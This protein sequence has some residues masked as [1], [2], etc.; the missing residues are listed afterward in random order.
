MN[1]HIF[2]ML[3]GVLVL[4]LLASGAVG[5]DGWWNTSLIKN[6]S[7]SNVSSSSKIIYVPDDYAKIQWAVDNASAGDTIIVRDGIYYENVNVN[8]RLTIRS[9]NGSANCIVDAR[10]SGDVIE[11]S[12][13]GITIE[14]FTVRNSGWGYRGIRVTSSNNNII[15]NN[16][17][18]NNWDG[19]FLVYSS[20]NTITNNCI[21]NNWDGIS[22]DD[23][24]NNNITNNCISNN[25]YYGIL[26]YY[27]SNNNIITNNCISNNSVGISLDYWSNNNIITNNCISSNNE[28]GIHLVHS[29][30]NTITGNTMINDGILIEGY[31][32]QHWNTHT[33]EDNTVNGKPLYYFK[34][35]VGGKVPED[36]GQVI[37]ANCTGMKIENLNVSNT[38]GGIV[39]GFSSQNT[40]KDNNI[41][42]N[43]DG[44][45]L[46]HS[47]N[48]TITNNCISSNNWSGIYLDCSSNN[49]IT[50]N[51][52]SNNDEGISL[53]YWS[54]NNTITNNCIS[55]NNWDGILLHDASN[56]IITNNCIS[57]NDDGIYLS[58]SGNNNITNNCISNNSVGI[59]LWSSKNNNITNNCISNNSLGIHLYDSSN[60]NITNNCISSNNDEGILLADSCCNIITNNC[61]SNNYWGIRLGG[62][63]N[64]IT[65]NCISNNTY[66][67]YLGYSSNNVIYLNNFINNTDQVY[68][69]KTNIWN[70]TSKI[71]Y[72]YK[73][74][75]Y[76]NYMGNYW[77]DYKG[78]DTDKD[79]IGDTPYS[80]DGD[81]DN[82]PL[83][84]RFENYT[85]E[86]SV[87]SPE[88]FISTDKYEYT[89]G[90]TMLINIS[91][92]NPTE[93]WR[94][95]KFLWRLDLPEYGL[96][97]PIINNKSLRLPPGFD[98]TFTMRWTLPS[99]RSS[100]TASWYVALYDAT[101]SEVIS[102]DKADWKYVP[103]TMTGEIVPEEIA[104]E[105]KEM[106]EKV[107]LPA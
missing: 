81:K 45:Y 66:G 96:Y 93:E 77:D 105:T 46:D 68:S 2:A 47:S 89:A 3:G 10:G 97:F 85:I 20:N 6:V 102:E 84:E 67:I 39:L 53:D 79:G 95:V 72:T 91:L 23:S 14:G 55:S 106:I 73:G 70:S 56:N 49:T 35:Q 57:N 22:L 28:E 26:L 30:N 76:T 78:N 75:T 92:E 98:K 21:S 52:I 62:S 16:C 90:D 5:A 24:S 38:D 7:Q 82:Y 58:Y 17:I 9:E 71:T 87:E 8:K 61:I 13:D 69:E 99:W 86:V 51:C 18:S 29:S 4:L 64:N 41:S 107:G 94:N 65:N 80:I 34:N 104:K 32:L 54:N 59:L 27:W 74:K 33:I 12:A 83:M 50:N 1:Q 19:I 11:L 88:V 42:D 60:N 100:F 103:I 63:N 37:L 48:N 25:S 43:L 15:T 101:T 31:E 44:I 36:V 40:V